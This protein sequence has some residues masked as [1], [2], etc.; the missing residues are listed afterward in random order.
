VACAFL[1]SIPN[2]AFAVDEYRI[3]GTF[4]GCEYDK[5]YEIVG[6]GILECREYNYFYEFGPRVIA[7]GRDVLLIGKEKV[8][9]TLHNG[10]V[11]TTHI[12]DDFEG[13]DFDKVY[14]LDNGLLFECATY[15]Y[16]YA[17]R[18]EVKIFVIE[19][20]SPVVFIR[21]RQYNGT[22]YRTQ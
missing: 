17:Y 14:R 21:G 22:L 18:P 2:D 1:L 11:V 20:R 19:G 5:L 6:G 10:S 7:D 12:S 3:A 16:Q 13:C 9:A 4:D 15:R 8:D